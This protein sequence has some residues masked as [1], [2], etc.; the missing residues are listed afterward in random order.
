MH[1]KKINTNIFITYIKLVKT[2]KMSFNFIQNKSVNQ[3]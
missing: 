2:F 1:R 3:A